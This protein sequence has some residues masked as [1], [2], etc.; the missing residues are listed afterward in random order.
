MPALLTRDLKK[1]HCNGPV[2]V[3]DH[4][5]TPILHVGRFSRGLG[6]FC[7][8][9]HQEPFELVDLEYPLTLITGRVLYQ[10]HTRT[11][12]GRCAGVN[13]MAPVAEVELNSA[14]SARMQIS[15]GEIVQI[16][17]RRG[18]IEARIKVTEVVQKGTIFIPFHYAKAAANT[19]TVAALDPVAKIPEFKVCAVRIEKRP[20]SML[21]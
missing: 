14:D 11:M 2:P 10:Y 3:V 18:V 16:S 20:Q 7:P 4:P 21:N 5:G 1:N 8:V 9:E 12:T 17:S 6:L 13:D 15:D 19:L